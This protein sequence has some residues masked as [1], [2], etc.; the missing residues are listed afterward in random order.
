MIRRLAVAASVAAAT[1][2]GHRAGTPPTV[3]MRDSAG[4]RI[5]ENR[6]DAAMAPLGWTVAPRPR[7]DVGGE[8]GAELYRVTGATRLGDGRIV[9]ASSGTAAIRIFS[10]GGAALRTVGRAGNGPGE[11]RALFWVGRLPGDSIGAWDSALGR[12]SVFTP[13]GDF[14]RSVAA[15]APLGVFPQAA[16]VLGDGRVLIATRGAA[17]AMG[18]GARVSRDEVTYV[19]LAT[20]GAVKPIGRFPGSEMLVTGG[21]GGG[22]LMRPLPFGR[23]TVAAAYGGRVFVGTGDA[24]EIRG[25][26]PGGALRSIVRAENEPPAV[27]RREIRAY[28]RALVTLGGEGD[29]HLRRV[30]DEMLAQAPYPRRMPP[31]VDLKVDAA[32]DLWVQAPRS[33]DDDGVR[34]RVFSPAGRL[35]G[36]VATPPA[37]TVREIGRDW[38]LGTALDADQSEHVRLYDLTRGDA[39]AARESRAPDRS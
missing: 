16:A 28:R 19:T 37:L 17:A 12:L 30:Q 18:S 33:A 8:A 6:G 11:F 20:D 15:T 22:F 39:R 7:V 23:Q 35:L 10:P 3:T 32:G 34:W 9:V 1:G 36:M 27:T 13:A 14:V 26:D 21:S 4:V 5:A 38:V 31:F 25:Y 24:F 2:C 29:A